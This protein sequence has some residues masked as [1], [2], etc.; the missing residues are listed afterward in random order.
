MSNITQFSENL[1]REYYEIQDIIT[2][3]EKR[4]LVIKGWGVTLSLAALAWGFQY[5]HYG[6]FLVACVSSIAFWIIEGVVKRHQMRFYVR[7]REIEV[8]NYELNS[9]TLT[10]EVHV[11]TPQINWSW[12]KA[13]QYLSGST[14]ASFLPPEYKKSRIGYTLAWFLPHVCLPHAI[15]IT[16]GGLLFMLGILGKI[17]MPL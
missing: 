6:L 12:K 10:D 11:S 5:Q 15:T 8:I 7:A 16:V 4:L 3:F 13:P 14:S 17:N 9:Y 1:N 2:G